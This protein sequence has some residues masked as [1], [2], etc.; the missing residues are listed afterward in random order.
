MGA[1][2]EEAKQRYL[3]IQEKN[4]LGG[5]QKHIDRQHGRGKLTARERIDV[6]ID[7]G[8]FNEIGSCVNTTGMRIDGV[9]GIAKAYATRVG[10]GP[11]ATEVEGEFGTGVALHVPFEMPQRWIG[12]RLRRIES[13][14]N[15]S[16]Q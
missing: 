5:G 6:L 9:V 15:G 13:V 12:S 1:R 10:G 14:G 7:L 16:G 3:E 4:K 2:M 8:T 11:F